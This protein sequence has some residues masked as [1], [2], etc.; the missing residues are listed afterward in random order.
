MKLRILVAAAVLHSYSP[1][2][3]LAYDCDTDCEKISWFH[4][5]CPTWR[6]PTRTCSGKNWGKFSACE[7]DKAISCD[8][9]EH[10]LAYFT[11]KIKALLHSH[12]NAESYQKA[13]YSG[14][15]AKYLAYCTAA[16]STAFLTLASEIV[17]P[18]GAFIV[19]TGG[20]YLSF[21]ICK[22]SPHW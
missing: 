10:A 14:E 4:Y 18:Y 20:A 17:G 1:A 21:R 22:E 19:G 5:T 6:N 11:P 13:L 15:E 16:V 7:A 8:L 9:R 3:S 12:Y 2:F